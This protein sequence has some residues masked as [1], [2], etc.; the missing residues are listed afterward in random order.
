MNIEEVTGKGSLER[1]WFDGSEG[2]SSGWDGLENT[3]GLLRGA[4]EGEEREQ[5]RER[6]SSRMNTG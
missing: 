5:A 2:H 6:E 1:G 3:P 4:L